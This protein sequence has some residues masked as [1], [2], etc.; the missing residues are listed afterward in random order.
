MNKQPDSFFIGKYLKKTCEISKAILNSDLVG[1]RLTKKNPEVLK[2]YNKLVKKPIETIERGT[3]GISPAR[4]LKEVLD[5]SLEDNKKYF[6]SDYIVQCFPHYGQTVNPY[7]WA[8]ISK[9]DKDGKSTYKTNSQIIISL[10]ANGMKY[11]FFHGDNCTDESLSVMNIKSNKYIFDGIV[12]AE[13]PADLDVEVEGVNQKVINY[14][15]EQLSNM[16][17]SGMNIAKRIKIEDLSGIRELDIF[18]DLSYLIELF[19]YSNKEHPSYYFTDYLL[20]EAGVKN[21]KSAKDYVNG[22]NKMEQ[23]SINEGICDKKFNIWN[24][25]NIYSLNNKLNGIHNRKWKVINDD[26]HEHRF[27]STPWN[28]WIKFNTSSLENNIYDYIGHCKNSDWLD[29]EKYKWKFSRW[30]EERVDFSK[31]SNEEILNILIQSQEQK[32][33]ENSNQKGVNFIKSGQR[34]SDSF[35]TLQDVQYIRTLLDENWDGKKPLIKHDST[36]PK[37]SVWLSIFSPKKFKPY[38]NNQLLSGIKCLSSEKGDFPK[39]GFKAFIFAMKEIEKIEKALRVN[40]KANFL[41]HQR[42][43]KARLSDLDWAWIAQDFVLFATR[44][45]AAPQSNKN[46]NKINIS[47][48]SKYWLLAPG[49]GARN[50]D[51]FYENGIAAIGWDDL[52]DLNDYET[53]DEIAIKLRELNNSDTSM[54]N[55]SLACFEFSKKIKLGDVIIP[56]KGQWTYLGYGI[57]V[58]NYIFNDS[59]KSYKHTLKVR[60]VKNGNFEETI[61]PIVTKTLTDITK[62]PEYVERLKRLMGIEGSEMKTYSKRD[63]LKDLFIQENEY[64]NIV[65]LLK[66][67]KNLILQ[68]PPGVGKSFAT[69]RIAYSMMGVVDKSRIETVQFHQSYSYEDFIRGY[70]PDKK[71]SLKPVDGIFLKFCDIARNDIENDYFFIIDE[72]NRGNLSKI[73]GELM[74]LIEKDKRGLSVKLAYENPDNPYDGFSIPKNIFII[75]TMNTA[76]RSLAMVDYA[77]RRRFVFYPLEPQFHS[78]K[79]QNYLIAKG[80]PEKLS[81]KILDRFKALNETIQ[82]D[83]KHLGNGYK[84]GHSYFCPDGDTDKPDDDWY[85]RIIKFEIQPLL[86]EY[87][88]D[89]LERAGNEI[90]NLF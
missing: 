32:Y 49:E 62:Y 9:K 40:D 89:D 12:N 47:E 38:A 2:Q 85:N 6:K 61:H 11:G 56:K 46:Q 75:G 17:N 54:K 60:W 44:I 53:K 76:D 36:Y 90:E 84:I 13:I 48:N 67:K 3:G 82:S 57:V 79:F 71:G 74:F 68:G 42:L 43:G 31:Q 80:V 1:K 29:N 10:R 25:H 65:E 66:Y 70:R 73:F 83:E 33:F 4:H 88:F 7:T 34:F 22:L 21:Q 30:V 81:K 59:R 45:L 52:G 55:D 41:F 24:R 27:F 39:I 35:I 26:A 50:W 77:L 23:W 20:S 18:K 14:T 69:A 51:D 63:A 58:S 86:N 64:D 15:S 28:H 78:K 37:L 5:F 87:W 8:C 19:I 72:I 16:W